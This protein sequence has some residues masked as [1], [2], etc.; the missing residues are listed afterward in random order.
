MAVNKQVKIF[1]QLFPE[2]RF[3]FYCNHINRYK[4]QQQNYL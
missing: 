2:S 1:G 3:A 4:K